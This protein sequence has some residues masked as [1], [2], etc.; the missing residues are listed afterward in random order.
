MISYAEAKRRVLEQLIPV[1]REAEETP[2][3]DSLGRVLAQTVYASEAVP[4]HDNSAM[5]GYAMRSADLG[6]Q[7]VSL[8]VVADLPAGSYFHTPLQAGEAVR[9]MTGAPIPPGSDCVVMQEQVKRQ[10][11]WVTV[12]PGQ[13]PGQ[14]I[15]P[16]GEDIAAGS[17]IFAAG[18]RLGVADLGLLTSL[19]K[20]T[21]PLF[22]RLRVALLSTGNEVV[23]PG[24]PLAP[25]QVYDS[26][27]A[28]LRAALTLLGV[29][30]IDLGSVRDDRE[31]LTAALRQGGEQADALITSGGVSVGDYDL[32]KEILLKDGQIDF[33]QVAMKPGKPQAYGRLGQAHFFGLP[34]NPVSS[35]TVYLLMVRPALLKM[36]GAATE[37]ERRFQARFR[38]SWHKRH[39]RMDFL[40]GIVHF[41]HPDGSPASSPW[42]EVTGAQGSGILTSLSKANV[43]IILPEGPAQIA[44]GDPVTVQWIDYA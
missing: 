14:N 8:R 18:R 43:F 3:T 28:T 30:V 16:A 17:A 27:R 41:D 29:E 38:G 22:R 31:A 11:E 4:N 34:G 44:D 10:G 21:L 12:P 42:V 39:S 35:L 25:G 2:L 5:D 15:R 40:R 7:A 33:W 24:Q 26:N 32:V 13:L 20:S 9:I 37:P 36:M 1:A 23:S 19:G 6:E